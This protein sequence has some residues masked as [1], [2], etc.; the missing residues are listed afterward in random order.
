MSIVAPWS[1]NWAWGLPLIVLIVILHVFGLSLIRERAVRAFNQV[2]QKYHPT[3]V[4]VVI[5]GAATLSATILHG[6]EAGVWAFAYKSLGAM[7]TY[8]I[9]ALYSLNAIT[10]YGHTNVSLPDHW[11]LMGALEAL[12]G[13][14][15]F[16]L[17]TAFLFAVIEKVWSLDRR[18]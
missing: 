7:P 1:N 4:F 13:W 9:A 17:S 8:R 2:S 5:V 12:N 16:G 6:I 10:S 14:L 15:L 18:R 11:H 3:A